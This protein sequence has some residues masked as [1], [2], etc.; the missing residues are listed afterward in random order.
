MDGGHDGE[1]V[2]Q[3]GQRLAAVHTAE[4][5]HRGDVGH[6][7]RHSSHVAGH[8]SHV[9]GHVTGH[10]S[11]IAGHSSHVAGHV[12][13]HSSHI[14]GHSSYIAGRV[15]GVGTQSAVAVSDVLLGEKRSKTFISWDC[16][17][18][19]CFAICPT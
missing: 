4:L 19:S 9:A 6:A 5:L 16:S 8:S 10:S 1:G 15:T 12:T 2:A 13:C 14:A 17:A 7:A 11:H 3:L 18:C